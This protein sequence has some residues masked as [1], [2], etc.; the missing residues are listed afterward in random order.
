MKIKFTPGA[1]LFF[2]EALGASFRKRGPSR[3]RQDKFYFILFPFLIVHIENFA[4]ILKMFD[5][6]PIRESDICQHSF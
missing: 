4:K 2:T 6:F 1:L 5:I 3:C